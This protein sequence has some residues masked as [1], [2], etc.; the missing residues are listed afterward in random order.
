MGP[1]SPRSK[2]SALA[3][4]LLLATAFVG[5]ATFARADWPRPQLGVEMSSVRFSPLVD[6]VAFREGVPESGIP[7]LPQPRLLEAEDT[8]LNGFSL[9]LSLHPDLV[10]A[11]TR[12][13]GSSQLRWFVDG[14]ERFDGQQADGVTTRLP[15]FEYTLQVYSLRWA[16]GRVRWRD[17]VGPVVGLGI[18]SI[19]QEQDGELNTDGRPLE[20]GDRDTVFEAMAGVEG[21]TRYARAGLDV[22]MARWVFEP[23]STTVPAEVV[24]AWQWVG[25]LRVGF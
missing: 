9:G 5:M 24:I 12:H 14:T 1:R 22:R 21:R 23:A 11:W 13:T 6:F 16:P 18:G 20:W 17:R 10:V 2:S 7:D 25:W 4:S 15:E 8:E 19:D 3:C